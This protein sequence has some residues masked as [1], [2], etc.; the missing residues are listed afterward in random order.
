MVYITH[1]LTQVSDHD[2]ILFTNCDEVRLTWLGVEIG[3]QKPE[4]GYEAMPHPPVIFKDVFDFHEISTNWRGRTGEIEMVAEGLIAGKVVCRQ[5]KKYPERLSGIRLEIDDVNIDLLAD[6]SDFVPVR[7]VL[8][9]NKG[10]PKVIS[11]EY[12]HF[13]VEGPGEIIESSIYGVNP[14]R[15]QFGVATVLI[16]ATTEVGEIQ[17]T[18]TSDGVGMDQIVLQSQAP[19]LPLL[20]D[21]S[22][23]CTSS[24]SNAGLTESQQ[25]SATNITRRLQ[26]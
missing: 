26:N 13:T 23:A 15:T 9:D 21:N 2:V 10:I 25:T 4:A 22:Y 19:L 7:A 5:V 18:A 1:E 20:Y 17:V 24:N 3:T 8:I 14:M 6:G 12:V 16:R 11:N